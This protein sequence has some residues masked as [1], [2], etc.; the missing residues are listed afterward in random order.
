MNNKSRRDF[1]IKSGYGLGGLAL[2]GM[3]PGLNGFSGAMASELAAGAGI[4]DPLA[5]KA[6]H[7]APKVKS[8]I[9]LH[10]DGAP[11]TIDLY[12]YK[13]QL[14]KMHGQDIPKSFMEGIKEGVRGGTG[15]LFATNRTWKQYG[16]S[17]A[18]FSD[19]LP[20]LAQHA[21]E[22]AF[23]KSSVTIARPITFRF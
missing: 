2:G 22:L 16:Q 11:S 13:P 12:D 20:N 10:M 21:D 19:L 5:P 9:W 6:P 17:G 3:L 15:K 8:V 4:V 23:I 18:W 14:V 7:F 1:L